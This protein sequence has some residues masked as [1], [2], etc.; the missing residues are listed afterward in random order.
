[1]NVIEFARFFAFL[2]IAGALIRL[3]EL[4]WG[5]KPGWQGSLAEGF[6]VIY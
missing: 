4:H 2:M 1:M 5:G 3:I 6:G